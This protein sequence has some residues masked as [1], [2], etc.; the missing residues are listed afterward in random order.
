MPKE[1]E[2]YIM[3][4]NY[5]S[6]FINTQ[7]MVFHRIYVNKMCSEFPRIETC[8]SSYIHLLY[9]HFN[10]H[11]W[12]LFCLHID[13]LTHLF[14]VWKYIIFSSSSSLIYFTSLPKKKMKNKK[15]KKG[16]QVRKTFIS[17]C[18]TDNCSHVERCKICS[19]RK[20]CAIRYVN[21]HIIKGES[22]QYVIFLNKAIKI[23]DMKFTAPFH[24]K[25]SN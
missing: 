14:L 23:V 1:L 25:E 16:R 9:I 11:I 3:H 21:V 22:R 4:G 5:F 8:F 10:Q 17:F 6:S 2:K 7:F 13:H 15:E 24:N 18:I 20:S 12:R 19:C